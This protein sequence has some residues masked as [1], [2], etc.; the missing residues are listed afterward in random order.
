[1]QSS[2]KSSL[3][4]KQAHQPNRGFLPKARYL[5]VP[6]LASAL[7]LGGCIAV[8]ETHVMFDQPLGPD[9]KP[10]AIR[11]PEVWPHKILVLPVSGHVHD[12]AR[13]EFERQFWAELQARNLWMLVGYDGVASTDPNL[14]ISEEAALLRAR[15]LGADGILQVSLGDEQIYSPIRISADV[16]IEDVA[17]RQPAFKM[18]CDYDSRN[19]LVA[20][21]ARRYYISSIQPTDAPDKSLSILSNR[22]E[23]LHFT[24]YYAAR[25]IAE[26]FAA[27][28]KA[29]KAEPVQADTPPPATGPAFAPVPGTPPG[30]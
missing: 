17:S 4:P 9:Y 30:K 28:K 26:A 16:V 12:D 21:S 20:T 8:D 10:V 22:Y 14:G 7:L 1:M 18:H 19:K 25:L 3:K 13:A 27:S 23:F 2:K 29:E 5:Q 24:G 15:E 11:Q 6:L